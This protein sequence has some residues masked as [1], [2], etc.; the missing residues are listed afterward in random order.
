MAGPGPI[1]RAVT[2]HKLG[3]GRRAAGGAVE[4]QQPAL[5]A[6]RLV[7]A[8]GEALPGARLSPGSGCD[9]VPRRR[10]PG[11]SAPS[12]RR[13]FRRLRRFPCWAA[14]GAWELR[15]FPGEPQLRSR[16]WLRPSA[17]ACVLGPLRGRAKAK[18]GGTASAAPA[19]GGRLRLA[20]TSFSV[21]WFRATLVVKYLGLCG[22]GHIGF[23]PRLLALASRFPL[24]SSRPL[25]SPPAAA[26]R[27][28]LRENCERRRLAWRPYTVRV[29]EG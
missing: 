14:R 21:S 22:P 28:A 8:A 11:P 3:C 27:S 2:W 20:P 17:R 12:L 23:T 13:P 19:P 15:A 5:R 29:D 25:S 18:R 9:R 26:L 1:A 16:R 24:C 10:G 7:P 4:S 6:P